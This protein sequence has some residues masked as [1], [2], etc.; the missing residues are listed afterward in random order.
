[1][2]LSIQIICGVMFGLTQATAQTTEI[3][4]SMPRGLSEAVDSLLNTDAEQEAFITR[5]VSRHTAEPIWSA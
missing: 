1:M 2:K 5:V 4:P 3:L